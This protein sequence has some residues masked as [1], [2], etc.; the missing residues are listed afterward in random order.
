VRRIRRLRADGLAEDI[1]LR[2]NV[3]PVQLVSDGFVDTVAGILAEFDIPRGALCL[4]ITESMVVQD[5][6]TT[7]TTLIGLHEAG[8]Q[9]AIDDFGTGYSVLS[10]LK[11]LP[12]DTLKVDRSFVRDLGASPGDL[13]IVRAIIALAEAFGLQLVAEG[14]ETDAAAATLLRHGCH[15]AQG[16]LISRPIS[17]PDMADLLRKGRVPLDFS[18]SGD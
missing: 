2:V 18:P 14:V 5:I 15:R 6:D 17:G 13:A 3:S 1:V 8:V 4:E 7:R 12:V 11:S 10:L 16:F 9:V